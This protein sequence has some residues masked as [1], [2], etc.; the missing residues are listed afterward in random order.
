MRDYQPHKNNP[1]WLE[2][3][4]YVRTLALIRDYDRMHKEYIAIATQGKSVSDIDGMPH[5]SNTADETFNKVNSMSAY[6]QDI[7]AV[8][9]AFEI[10]P[11]EYRRGVWRNITQN[12]RYPDDASKRTYAIHKQRFIWKVAQNKFW[13]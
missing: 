2:R 8:E 5:G 11:P 3:S 6:W 7:Q 9:Q 12:V 1:Y 10:V 13:I 4:L